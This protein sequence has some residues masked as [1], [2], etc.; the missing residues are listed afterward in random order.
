MQ[1]AEYQE[2]LEDLRA[3]KPRS[4]QL[5]EIA[6]LNKPIYSERAFGIGSVG[7]AFLHVYESSLG[8]MTTGDYPKMFDIK[9]KYDEAS[10]SD[11]RLRNTKIA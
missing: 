5:D 8:G 9:L 11:N 3:K 1:H 7:N 4:E 6:E 10:G 2:K